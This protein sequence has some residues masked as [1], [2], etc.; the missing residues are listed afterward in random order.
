[1]K[2]KPIKNLH[3]LRYHQELLRLQLSNQEQELNNSWVYLKTNYKKMVWQEVNPFKGNSVLDTALGLLQP[4]LLPI[5]TE[6]AKGATKGKPLNLK[7]LGS[8][9]K[10]M[11][12]TLGIK[13]LRKWLDLKQEEADAAE[14][15]GNEEIAQ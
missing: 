1:M 3:D 4:G 2:T 15:V 10:F 14:E 6:V 13:W 5:I 7:V 11:V 12:A 9:A 8:S